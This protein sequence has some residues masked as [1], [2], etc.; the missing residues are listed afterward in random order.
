ML[1]LGQAS[2]FLDKLRKDGRWRVLEINPGKVIH[3][4]DRY[5]LKDDITNASSPTTVQ[6]LATTAILMAKQDTSD[7][8]I[9]AALESWYSLE[10]STNRISMKEASQWTELRL[11]PAAEQYFRDHAEDQ[12]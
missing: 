11:H 3:A 9:T 8:L 2:P 4:F 5:P 1:C 10:D 7:A 6:T 12:E